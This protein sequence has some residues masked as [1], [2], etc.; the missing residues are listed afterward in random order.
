MLI[1]FEC[2]EKWL[3]ET[4][5]QFPPPKSTGREEFGVND[6]ERRLL[7]INSENKN[8]VIATLSSFTAF[9][10][11]QELEHFFQRES[12]KPYE[13]FVAGGGSKNAF[14]LKEITNRCRGIR[15]STTE[16]FGIPVEAREAMAFALLAWWNFHDKPCSNAI[17]GSQRPSVL[18]SL[19]QPK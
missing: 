1:Y 16:E 11:A 6:L 12:I 4:F 19:V 9:V 13:L 7:E 8:D 5:F 14:L 15:V 3:E 10:V 17:T 2:I 18:G